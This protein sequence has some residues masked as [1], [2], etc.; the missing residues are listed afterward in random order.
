[1]LL[2]RE[3]FCNH[4]CTDLTPVISSKIKVAHD[5]RP[6]WRIPSSKGLWFFSFTLLD[7]YPANNKHDFLDMPTPQS[8]VDYLTDRDVHF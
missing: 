5:D 4:Y 6:A 1:M 8:V 2:K 3:F 7:I